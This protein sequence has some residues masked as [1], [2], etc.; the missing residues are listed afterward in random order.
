MGEDLNEA[1]RMGMV[2]DV[3]VIPKIGK[4]QVAKSESLPFLSNSLEE[5]E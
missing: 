3:C 1:G 5:W 2:L 4:C